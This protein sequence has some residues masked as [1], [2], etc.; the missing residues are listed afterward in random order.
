MSVRA[1]K[2][3]HV[4]KV[5]V[6]SQVLDAELV[7]MRREQIVAAAV[8]L[9]S[10]NGYFKTT[11]LEIAQKAGI[12]V[13]LIYHYARTK[14]DV[15]FLTLMSVLESYKREIPAVDPRDTPLESL[16]K[17]LNAYG[18]VIDRRRA[19]A[20]LAYRSTKSLPTAQRRTIMH[21]EI[22]TNDL[23]AQRV[24]ACVAA[25]LF[26]EE[27]NVD[28]AVYQLIMHA[29]TW[30]LKHWHLKEITTLDG[31]IRAGFESAV[32]ASATPAGLSAYER[33]SRSLAHR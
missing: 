15:L 17:A 16:W 27:I 23:L 19:A 21:L 11:I 3:Q 28:L 8:E 18:R 26:R 10:K 20:V 12:S 6:K 33:F 5:T 1:D 30:A 13:G 4:R 31:Y 14:E 2:K 7:E 29:H 32:R 25:K 24:Q 22:E 9:F